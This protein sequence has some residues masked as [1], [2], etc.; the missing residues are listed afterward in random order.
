MIRR[1]SAPALCLMLA[2]APAGLRAQ[3]HQASGAQSPYAGFE[4]RA[5]KSL[6]KADIDELRQGGGWGLALPAELNGM[7]GPAHLLELKDEIGLSADQV[8]TIEAIYAEMKS[9]ALAAGEKLIAAEK[10]IEQAIVGGQLDEERLRTLIDQ[11]AAARADLRFIHLSRHLK[12][13][14]LLTSEQ[15]ERYKALRG[16]ASDSDPCANVPAGHDADMWR[17]HNGCD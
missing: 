14:P 11:S 3:D 13:P 12:T 1:F 15:I 8:A 7:P 2:L 16:Y 5:I 4:T 17:R 10:A 6:S 9:E